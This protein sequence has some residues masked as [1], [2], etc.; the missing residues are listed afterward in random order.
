M[1]SGMAI[2]SLVHLLKCSFS[3]TDGSD[4]GE[5]TLSQ[6]GIVNRRTKEHSYARPSS[7]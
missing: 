2:L 4:W 1:H 7:E 3:S 6:D 5:P